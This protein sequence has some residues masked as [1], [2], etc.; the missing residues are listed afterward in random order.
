MIE[1]DRLLGLILVA[2]GEVGDE[3][4]T[5]ARHAGTLVVDEAHMCH[6]LLFKRDHL[7]VINARALDELT[8]ER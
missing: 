7:Q 6:D 3:V 5:D 2:F 1:P 4:L 8:R